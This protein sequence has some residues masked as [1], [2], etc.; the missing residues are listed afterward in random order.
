MGRSKK[1]SDNEE[2]HED[3]EVKKKTSIPLIRITCNNCGDSRPSIFPD[4]KEG[5]GGVRCH[6]CNKFDNFCSTFKIEDKKISWITVP[7]FELN[8]E[9]KVSFL[10]K[11]DKPSSIQSFFKNNQCSLSEIK[12]IFI[13]LG[14]LDFERTQKHYSVIKN[15]KD[16]EEQKEKE[17][18]LSKQLKKII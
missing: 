10:V 7:Y 11:N 4:P 8:D 2:V 3:E 1:I 14:I 18:K 12:N 5:Y 13:E 17:N 9:S 6:S 16:T 15:A